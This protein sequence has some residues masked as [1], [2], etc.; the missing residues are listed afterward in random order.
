M[1]DKTNTRWDEQFVDQAWSHMSE[2]LDRELPVAADRKRRRGLIL[3]FFL[4]LG[5]TLG[6]LAVYYGTT[7][8]NKNQKDTNF[9]PPVALQSDEKPSLNESPKVHNP[10][11]LQHV[12]GSTLPIVKSNSQEEDLESANSNLKRSSDAKKSSSNLRITDTPEAIGDN[13]LEAKSE[14]LKLDLSNDELSTKAPSEK[15][16]EPLTLTSEE[17][18]RLDQKEDVAF[19]KEKKVDLTS[20]AMSLTSSLEQV[21]F[22]LLPDRFDFALPLEADHLKNHK[23]FDWGVEAGLNYAGGA[24]Y[25]GGAHTHYSFSRRLGL[26]SGLHFG[27][28]VASLNGSQNATEESIGTGN[29]VTLNP[30]GPTGITGTPVNPDQP[31]NK[32]AYS[33][34][35]YRLTQLSAPVLLTYRADL[36]WRLAVG[37]RFNYLLTTS[38]VLP[39]GAQAD[40][41]AVDQ[42]FNRGQEQNNLQAVSRPLVIEDFRRLNVG[43]VANIGFLA[44]PRWAFQLQY[45]YLPGNWLKENTFLLRSNN[46]RV[47]AVYYFSA[48]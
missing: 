47:S 27:D 24:G 34:Y 21:E 9:K 16:A 11:D 36:R 13:L 26:Q 22:S 3:L 30:G 40:Y 19:T 33:N 43:A 31:Q 38:A 32:T 25:F 48:R 12:E 41:S 4:L 8:Q 29:P 15:L 28:M 6:S 17:T 44:T 42:N 35:N 37:A 7:P 39:G 2:L 20:P 10:R 23:R 14:K 46:V 1:Q 18:N 5:L 45:E